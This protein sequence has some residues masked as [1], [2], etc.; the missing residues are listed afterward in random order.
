MASGDEKRDEN[1]EEKK[2][3]GR[4]KGA[5]GK[6]KR[7][8]T[9]RKY[10]KKLPASRG[11]GRKP[12][13]ASAVTQSPQEQVD[14]NQHSD[15]QTVERKCQH[16]LWKYFKNYLNIFF[17]FL[18]PSPPN[19]CEEEVEATE[20]EIAVEIPGKHDIVANDCMTFF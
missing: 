5:K 13:V 9:K 2:K 18:V 14:D 4:P 7:I 16:F 12:G 1:G 19:Y 17:Y 3:P 11:G 6:P 15:D 20:G 8:G 10:K